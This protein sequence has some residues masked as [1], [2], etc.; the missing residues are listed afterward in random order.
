M[1]SG[2]ESPLESGHNRVARK[3]EWAILIFK[4]I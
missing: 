1:I 3:T 2:V 4:D